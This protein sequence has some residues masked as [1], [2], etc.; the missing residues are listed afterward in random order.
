MRSG[1]KFGDVS[2]TDSMMTDGLI[3]AFNNY[4]MGI[5]GKPFPSTGHRGHV[6][7]AQVVLCSQAEPQPGGKT[8]AE[9]G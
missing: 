3:D 8:A 6:I 7:R 2:M 4:H 9:E 1:V 5:T